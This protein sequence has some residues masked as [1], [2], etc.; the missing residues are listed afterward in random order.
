MASYN[1]QG[2]HTPTLVQALQPMLAQPMTTTPQVNAPTGGAPVYQMTP[3]PP[4]AAQN[5]VTLPVIDP[6][7]SNV[8][9]PNY[10]SGRGG[11]GGTG[12]AYNPYAYNPYAEQPIVAPGAPPAN[13]PPMQVL[14]AYPLPYTP[15]PSG[16][17]GGGGGGIG[18]AIGFQTPPPT[19][20]AP[21]P[22]ATAAPSSIPWGLIATGAAFLL[23]Q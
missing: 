23:S 20:V 1:Y 11:G 3:T 15:P 13:S 8:N 14:P 6:T 9:S 2:A 10:S 19:T 16:G 12:T 18:P 5:P 4:P 21:T 7:K 17:G 22:V